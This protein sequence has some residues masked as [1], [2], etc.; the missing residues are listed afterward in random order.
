M[1]FICI[2][3]PVAGLILARLAFGYDMLPLLF[4]L[5]SG[6]ALIGPIAAVHPAAA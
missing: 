2:I 3:Y 6:F 4:P 1:I 5:A